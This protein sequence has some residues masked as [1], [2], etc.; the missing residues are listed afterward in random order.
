MLPI[1]AH[2]PPLIWNIIK[3]PVWFST[4]GNVCFIK[5]LIVVTAQLQS[6]LKL[7]LK[8]MKLMW[9]HIWVEPTQPPTHKLLRHFQ[10]T[11][12]AEIWYTG[13]FEWFTKL[14]RKEKHYFIQFDV[15]DYYASIT[16]ELIKNSIAFAERYVEISDEEKDTI[17]QA[18]NS[19]L[20][21]EGKDW[22]KRQGKTFDI[23]MG[24]FHGAEICDLAGLYL[25]SLL[26]E[27]LPNVGLY[28][29]DGLGVS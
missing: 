11:S 15:V 26:K 2:P 22:I 1:H 21:N 27:V 17:F 8:L 12:K 3:H 29:D 13:L 23:T 10:V 25:L 16:P 18:C 6:K 5:T 9:P 20:W 19:F 4:L 24:G 14:E 28:R 7:K